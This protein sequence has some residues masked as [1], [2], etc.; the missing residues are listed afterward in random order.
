[1]EHKDGHDEK[2]SIIREDL[3]LITVGVLPVIMPLVAKWAGLRN[4]F[5]KESV[6]DLKKRYREIAEE[7]TCPACLKQAV[8]TLETGGRL[9]TVHWIKQQIGWDSDPLDPRSH[10]SIE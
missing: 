3:A 8:E 2:F 7:I 6:A 9:D 4:P 1:V 5:A 10:D